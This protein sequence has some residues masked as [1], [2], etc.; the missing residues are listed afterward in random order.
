M[1]DAK[2]LNPI[3]EQ[4]LF[5]S[6]EEY[7]VVSSALFA[8]CEQAEKKK[9]AKI[10]GTLQAVLIRMDNAKREGGGLTEDSLARFDGRIAR[11]YEAG[12][13][14]QLSLA[15]Q[16]LIAAT[17]RTDADASS[18]VAAYLLKLLEGVTVAKAKAAQLSGAQLLAEFAKRLEDATREWNDEAKG[19]PK[20]WPSSQHVVQWVIETL[21]GASENLKEGF[22]AFP[23]EDA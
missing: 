22:E 7:E 16:D 8:L 2:P 6:S 21:V 13:P 19:D 17:F 11:A 10:F 1:T 15:V 18:K 20:K 3:V 4:G 5:F 14:A 12:N 9:N 23:K